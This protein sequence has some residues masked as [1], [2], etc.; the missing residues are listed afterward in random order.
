MDQSTEFKQL[1]VFAAWLK[2]WDRLRGEHTFETD[3][4]IGLIDFGGTLGSRAEGNPKPGQVFSP[5]I[6][7]FEKAI[8][9]KEIYQDFDVSWIF[10]S[11]AWQNISLFTF[12]EAAGKLAAVSDEDI[13]EAVAL[14]QYSNASDAKEMAEALK[15][16]RDALVQYL[17][18]DIELNP[19]KR[20]H[21]VALPTQQARRALG[22]EAPAVTSESLS[23]V[24]RELV[25]EGLAGIYM[26]RNSDSTGD[27]SQLMPQHPRVRLLSDQV[28]AY[29]IDVGYQVNADEAG[30]VASYMMMKTHR[31]IIDNE[32]YRLWLKGELYSSEHTNAVDSLPGRS[33]Y[34]E[35]AINEKSFQIF[36]RLFEKFPQFLT[37]LELYRGA[38]L[39]N[40]SLL[41]LVGSI[42]DSRG[43]TSASLDPVVAEEFMKPKREHAKFSEDVVRVFYV[44]KA[45]PSVKAIFAPLLGWEYNRAI[46]HVAPISPNIL[47]EEEIMMHPST[48]FRVLSVTSESDS[49]GPYSEFELE[50][51]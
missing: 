38:V 13:E 24:Q 32:A 25:S 26:E 20:T 9:G 37:G 12:R 19:D 51:F 31:R 28:L 39:A 14:A 34:K 35:Q 47:R 18:D 48:Q 10:E 49:V 3:S 16:R 27:K 29:L 36:E 15:S 2:D 30:V 42:I 46:N 45:Q 22:S 33:Y 41:P 5:Q 1:R 6:G 21:S 11:H 7:T 23:Y 43:V 44:V 40:Q 50:A 17:Y 4:D 8:S